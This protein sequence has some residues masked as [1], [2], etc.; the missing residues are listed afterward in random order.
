VPLTPIGDLQASIEEALRR[1][2]DAITELAASKQR[3]ADLTRDRASYLEQ[4]AQ[5][6]ARIVKLR[7]RIEM[8]LNALSPLCVERRDDSGWCL[9]CRTERS[10]GHHASCVQQKARLVLQEPNVDL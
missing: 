7:L 3:I 8:Y 4:I 1:F 10:L 5:Y 6:E 2:A 9:W